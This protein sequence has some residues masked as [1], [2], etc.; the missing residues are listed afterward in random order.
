MLTVALQKCAEEKLKMPT[1]R[2]TV[3]AFVG[4][5]EFDSG[6]IGRLHWW[7]EQLGDTPLTEVTP[8]MVD[9]AIV[10]LTQRG[11]LKVVKGQRVATGQPIGP[12][13]LNRY[14][15]QLGSVYKFARK[16]RLIRRTFVFP[17]VG[18]EKGQEKI[19]PNRYLRPEE[20][21]KLLVAAKVT[22]R[23]WGKLTALILV[24]YHTGLR[25]SNVIRLRWADVDLVNRTATVLETKN[26]EP[27]VAALSRPSVEALEKIPGRHLPDAYI[28]AGRSG[29]PLD[30]RKLWEN[31][32][33]LAGLKGKNFH[34]LR[35]GC[36]H[37]LAT[38]GI[39]QASI[40]AV[41]GHKTLTASA[42]YMHHNL[43]DKRQIVARVFD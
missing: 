41:M 32:T 33:E 34:Q 24:A 7:T 22:D 28:F 3:A 40:M 27:Q 4:S 13:T 14:I 11:K 35:H 36:G 10:N 1:F 12:A 21:D 2:E 19:D 15:S 5:R 29:R 20:V 42:R 23:K 8:D 39:N 25:K 38:A 16:H 26:G 17:T 31:T 6:T 30:F 37:A 43:N 9:D 18:I